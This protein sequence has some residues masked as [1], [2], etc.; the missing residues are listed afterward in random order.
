M[1]IFGG[2]DILWLSFMGPYNFGLDL[3]VISMHFSILMSR[4]RMVEILE[5]AKI[6]KILFWC[7]IFL[8]FLG[9]EW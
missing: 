3:E 8:I 5:D 4:Y 6:S 9:D 7:L 1:N 2:M